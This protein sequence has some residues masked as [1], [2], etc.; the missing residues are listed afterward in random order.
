MSMVVPLARHGET[1]LCLH[2][3]LGGVLGGVPLGSRLAE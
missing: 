3:V 2:G 1:V